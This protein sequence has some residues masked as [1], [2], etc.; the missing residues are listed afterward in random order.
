MPI[1]RK[2]TQTPD[3]KK[4]TLHADIERRR[5]DRGPKVE[6]SFSLL[7]SIVFRYTDSRAERH[8]IGDLI[9]VNNRQCTIQ[10]IEKSVLGNVIYRRY[11]LELVK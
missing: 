9:M 5:E 2:N 11:I 7:S 8:N 1:T 3:E 10:D 4:A 6:H